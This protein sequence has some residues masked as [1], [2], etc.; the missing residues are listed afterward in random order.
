MFYNK[1]MFVK[2]VNYYKIYIIFL[3]THLFFINKSKF[4]INNYLFQ[5]TSFATII[6]LFLPYYIQYIMLFINTKP[7]Y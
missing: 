1:Y 3:A 4:K 2:M 7:I 6:K 5:K